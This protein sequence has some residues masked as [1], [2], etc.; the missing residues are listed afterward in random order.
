MRHAKPTLTIAALLLA[1][2]PSLAEG[3][4]SLEATLAHHATLHDVAFHDARLGWAVGDRGLVLRTEDGGDHWTRIE[5][6]TGASLH[7]VCF[8]D[9]NRGWAA[10]GLT[11]PYTHETEAV[12]LH[13]DDGGRE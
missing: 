10:G 12:L 9:A 11:R 6:P 1:A 4:P 7:S 3:L 8:I 13:T 2:T 5:T